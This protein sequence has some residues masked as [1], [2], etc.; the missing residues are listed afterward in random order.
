[1][2]LIPTNLSSFVIYSSDDISPFDTIVKPFSQLAVS[3]GFNSCEMEQFTTSY[4]ISP[5][6][7]GVI[8]CVLLL[9]ASY[10]IANNFFK[11]SALVAE[12]PIPL[13]FI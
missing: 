9:R 2:H 12:V 4:T 3:S 6:S 5:K 11:I 1:M 8:I 10:L 7:V 13:P